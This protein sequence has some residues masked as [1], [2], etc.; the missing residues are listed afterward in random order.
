MKDRI[1]ELTE[2]LEKELVEVNEKIYENPELGHQ[3]HK[4]AKLHID[5]L[6]KY[7]FQVEESYMDI[8]TGFRAEYDSKKEGPRVAFLIEYDALPGIGHGCGHNILGAVSSGASI[9]L[10]QV[11]DEIGGKVVAFGTPAEETNGTKV[12]FVDKGAFDD[13]DFAMIAHPNFT[14]NRSGKSLALEALEFEFTGK[15]SHA[16]AAPEK[17]INALDAAINTFNSINALR[18]QTR[19][20]ARIHGIIPQGGEAANII[21]ERAVAQFY[22][23][24]QTKSYLDGLVERVKN[25]AKGAAL[26]AGAELKISNYELSY[27]N[28]VTNHTMDNLFVEKIVELGIPKEEI[29]DPREGNGSSDAGNVSHVCPTIHPYFDIT[30]DENIAPHTREF[31][32]CTLTEY[33]YKNMKITIEALVLTSVEIIKDRKLMK[34]IKKEFEKAEK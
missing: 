28:L 5:L 14:Y 18:Q 24:A 23:R 17:G 3:E 21:P 22:V 4:S 33:A 26:G 20:D 12:V 25:C 34:K 6:K 13:V 7:G 16:A 29:K 31:A 15:T 27:H 9:V 10:K 32:S 8:E 1:I 30:N 2:K 19:S 11:I